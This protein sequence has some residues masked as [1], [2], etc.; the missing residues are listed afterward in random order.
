MTK[1]Q[2]LD[3]RYKKLCNFAR[4]VRKH[5]SRKLGLAMLGFFRDKW[6]DSFN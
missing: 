6:S 2:R 3:K 4:F 5:I 1:R